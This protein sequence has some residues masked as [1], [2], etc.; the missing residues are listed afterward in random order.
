MAKDIYKLYGFLISIII[1]VTKFQHKKCIS[2]TNVRN[3]GLLDKK[4][5]S[6]KIFGKIMKMH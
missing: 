2:N 3:T 1:F 4:R 5:L 6:K